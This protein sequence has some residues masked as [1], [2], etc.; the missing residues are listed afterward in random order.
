MPLTLT[1]DE[2]A[3]ALSSAHEIN[4]YDAAISAAASERGCDTV[5]S[6]DMQHGK[7][8]AAL[9]TENPFR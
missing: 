5:L 8:F 6:E 3:L 7:K 4:I 9:R 1:I 2:R